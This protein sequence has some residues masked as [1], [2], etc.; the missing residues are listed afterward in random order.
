MSTTDYP[1]PCRIVDTRGQS[2]RLRFRTDDGAH[3]A[4][5]GQLV[6]LRDDTDEAT[7]IELTRDGVR[8]AEIDT[9]I[10]RW[11]EWATTIRSGPDGITSELTL[12]E[13]QR[14]FAVTDLSP[15]TGTP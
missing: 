3:A 7:P 10:G 1:A 9:E 4:A 11:L 8:L 5:T 6:A 15:R 14:R 13:V 2:Y 12:T